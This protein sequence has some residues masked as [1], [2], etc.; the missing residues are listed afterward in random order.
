VKKQLKIL[1]GQLG[2]RG[3]CLYA[4]TIARQIKQDYPHCHLTWAISSPYRSILD[5]NP[6][7]DEV[8]EV[9]QLNADSTVETWNQFQSEAI[10]KKEM[11]EYDELFFTQ[12]APAN[13]QNFDGTCRSSLFRGYP[14]P[15]TVPI[16]PI[17]RLYEH[18]VL[19]VKDFVAKNQ[20]TP[21]DVVVLFECSS[22]S[23]QS[24]VTPEFAIRTAQT[25]IQKNNHVKFILSSDK[26]LSLPLPNIID[27][28]T[29]TFR[30]NAEITHYCN[31][32]I[33]CSSG[34][35]WLATSNWAKPLPQIQLLNKMTG[36]YASML[37]D[38]KYFQLST[39]HILELVD[40]ASEQV[41]AIVL[42]IL[43]RGFHAAREKYQQEIPLQYNFYFSQLDY[44]LLSKK[45]HLKA[46]HA[47]GTALL[48]YHYDKRGMEEL[49]RTIKKVLAPYVKAHWNK[50]N[51]EEKNAFYKIGAQGSAH[52]FLIDWWISVF[53]LLLSSVYGSRTRIA[54]HL[55]LTTLRHSIEKNR[56]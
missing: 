51:D 10:A 30:E 22:T 47:V 52:P 49:R 38:A 18:E 16:Q 41:S 13:F 4:T 46:A 3:D 54:R 43:E 42:D 28:S 55:L 29:L 17:I 8:W 23:G 5:N 37:N 24:Y 2:R 36:M 6:F 35:S 48:R 44:E 9:K 21:Q 11:G 31:L 25:V 56:V 20:I 53:Q 33:G 50:L 1:L 34:I 40:A 32:I 19:R 26:P 12:I 39:D 15:I 7:V 27:G 45:M 14:H